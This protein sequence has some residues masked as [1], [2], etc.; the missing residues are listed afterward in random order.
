MRRLL[1]KMACLIPC[2]G[3]KDLQRPSETATLLAEL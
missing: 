1:R 2:A 3:T